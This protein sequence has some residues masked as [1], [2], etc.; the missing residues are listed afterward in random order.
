M[1]KLL[2]VLS[3]A[4]ILFLS[5]SIESSAASNAYIVKSGDSLYKI[6]KMTN[7][8]VS[9]LK[10]WNGL[11]SNTIYPNQKLKLKK[12]TVKT[13]SKKATA[14][15]SGSST[16]YTVKRGDTLYKISKSQKVSVS[17]LKAWN[18][19]K[20]STI[21]PNQ[22]LKLNKTATTVSKKQLLLV[23]QMGR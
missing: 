18:G 16:V 23:Q 19:L 13:V 9:N 4:L 14:S 6:S 15:K 11:K 10:A 17:N 20:S 21:Y 3:F 12:A 1:K 5:T 7:V 22:K 2:M 8:S